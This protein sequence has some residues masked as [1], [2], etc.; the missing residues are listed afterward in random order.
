[1]SMSTVEEIIGTGFTDDARTS[2][3]PEGRYYTDPHVHQMELDRVFGYEWN[4]ICHQ[5]QLPEAG[6]YMVRNVG[7]ESIYVIRGRDDEI[8][9]F[10]NVCQHRG[11]QLLEGQGTVGKVVVCPYHAWSYSAD[12]S[13]RGAPRM[14]D[15]PNFCKADVALTSIR[16]ELVGGFVFINLDEDARPLG[17]M[18]PRFEPILRSMVAEP[19]ALRHVKTSGFD[20]AANWKVVTENF[21][22][23]YHVE[24][25]GPA[26]RALA[27]I[28][29]TD[30][31]EFDISGRTIEYRAKGGANDALPYQANQTD[32]FA[33]AAGPPFHQVFLF[34][35]MTF[36]IFPGT[37]MLFV[38][39]MAPNG[40]ERCDEE[41]LYF[42]LD[43]EVTEPTAEAEAY[44]SEQLN[45][46]DV[47]LVESVHRGLRSRGY[48]PGRFMVDEE[49]RA[50][51]SEQFVHHFNL[52]NIMALERNRDIGRDTAP[53]EI[54]S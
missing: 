22:E 49:Q 37:N 18:A 35:H 19:E 50:S 39:N 7:G 1:M 24:F 2:H 15:V 41:I 14:R 45:V 4:Y 26:H 42:T 10:C 20:I 36:S 11:H 27:N 21:L 28:I 16:T 43:A 25:S 29:D 40:V 54:E 30:T 53:V 33:D 23:A 47:Q 12:G 52:L 46:E 34:P 17:E 48:R 6:S 13:L 44:V 51:W 9:A 8:R 5:S 38:F 32:A 31:Y 3:A